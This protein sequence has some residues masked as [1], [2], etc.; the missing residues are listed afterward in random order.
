MTE[1]MYE[2]RLRGP[3]SSRTLSIFEDLDMHY[4]TML[5]GV[6]VDQAALHGLFDRIRDLRL[7]IIDVHQIPAYPLPEP[8]A[9]PH[10]ERGGSTL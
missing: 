9:I 2:L 8:A 1:T 10:R 6:I 7:E 4:D 5:R 3:V